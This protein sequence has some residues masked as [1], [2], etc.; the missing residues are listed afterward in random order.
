MKSSVA[1]Y[2][3]IALLLIFT[4]SRKI[5]I[6]TI[7]YDL[8]PEQPVNKIEL[9][10]KSQNIAE[11]D[12]QDLINNIRR[13]VFDP[14]SESIELGNGP[15]LLPKNIGILRD[16]YV[17]NEIFLV[18]AFPVKF[19]VNF[20]T[21]KPGLFEDKNLS[22]FDLNDYKLIKKAFRNYKEF[23]KLFFEFCEYFSI[24]INENKLE[25][26]NSKDSKNKESENK[27]I[28]NIQKEFSEKK[29]SIGKDQMVNEESARKLKVLHKNLSKKLDV[30]SESLNK[31]LNICKSKLDN[32]SNR[33]F[34]MFY[35]FGELEA[36]LV[37]CG[38]EM[39]YQKKLAFFGQFGKL[40][41]IWA[42]AFQKLISSLENF[43]AHFLFLHIT[44]GS[45]FSSDEEK[46]REIFMKIKERKVDFK[47]SL[48]QFE[49]FDTVF[50]MIDFELTR[51]LL[52]FSGKQKSVKEFSDKKF[53]Y[54]S[55][56]EESD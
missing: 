42:Y 19:K 53:L 46:V 29:Q 34:E 49:E 40:N 35:F 52:N 20:P 27:N 13:T 7:V 37:G 10:K 15:K 54:F 33:V 38:K 25:G 55:E 43:R 14:L 41:K 9:N 22:G 32:H 12:K 56:N 30:V 2:A 50:E 18:E 36:F 4:I 11:I 21:E 23:D 17:Q 24:S 47:S 6:N 31:A 44:L 16:F 1:F 45:M 51:I 8:Y 28:E 48:E 5:P 39:P 26:K 3:R